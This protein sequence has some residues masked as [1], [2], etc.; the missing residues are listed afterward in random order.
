MRSRFTVSNPLI[1]SIICPPVYLSIPTW[2]FCDFMSV[3]LVIRRP[4]GTW[5]NSSRHWIPTLEINTNTFP[6]WGSSIATQLSQHWIPKDPSE[7]QW[8]LYAVI[9]IYLW[10]FWV[11]IHITQ[12]CEHSMRWHAM[13]LNPLSGSIICVSVC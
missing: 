10:R 6:V 1:I 4:F 9:S 13:G 5:I 8:H 11:N 7:V 12:N 3:C 2:A